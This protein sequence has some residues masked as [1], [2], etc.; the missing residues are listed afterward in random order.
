MKKLLLVLLCFTQLAHAVRTLPDA[1]KRF[2]QSLKSYLQSKNATDA[3]KVVDEY[4]SVENNDK[5]RRT[6]DSTLQVNKLTI[7]QLRSMAAAATK[8]PTRAPSTPAAP[9]V[10]PI[11]GTIGGTASGKLKPALSPMQIMR[12]A[13][14]AKATAA[15]TS[16]LSEAE[17][18]AIEQAIAD[19]T[20]LDLSRATV[21]QLTNAINALKATIKTGISKD[22]RARINAA[23][24]RLAE[25]RQKI[26][27]KAASPEVQI[28]FGSTFEEENPT[29]QTFRG[30]EEIQ[31][32]R[33]A[34]ERAAERTAHEQ[35]IHEQA[36]ED[37]EEHFGGVNAITGHGI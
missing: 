37:I 24:K 18:E 8:A 28:A 25:Q 22:Q 19:A 9:T 23:I 16:L 17:D 4:D 3:Q 34:Q 5:Y 11:M 36:Q 7:G 6:F 15:P 32:E 2:Q 12:Q 14:G 29:V 35:A 20:A 31:A 33:E 26:K 27:P 13:S 21:E 1:S 10:A 30:T